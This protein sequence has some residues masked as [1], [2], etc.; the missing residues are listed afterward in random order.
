M[1]SGGLRT[2]GI[3]KQ[4]GLD[5]P[6]IT[7]VTVVRN[8]EKTLERTMLSVINQTYPNVEYIVI[9]G[10]SSDGTV[11]IIK[12]Y[13]DQIDYW[14]SEPDEGIYDAMNKAMDIAT[15][16]W[17]IFMNGGDCF[18]ETTIVNKCIEK[19]KDKKV[20]YYGDVY[21]TVIRKIYCGA[22]SRFKLAVKNICHQNIFY[23]KYIYKEY[24]YQAKYSPLSDY[25]YNISIYNKVCF[26]YLDETVAKFEYGGRSTSLKN[27]AFE[28][29]VLLV[30]LKNLGFFPFLWRIIRTKIVF[31][32]FNRIKANKFTILL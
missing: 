3:S 19:M 29:D 26:R 12:R 21:W 8:G 31:N 16:D 10:A 20:L 5:M 28:K 18:F 15:G 2:K 1:Q 25:Y 9:D 11:D 27:K 7:V 22:F 14:L 13:E 30:I 4:S 6:L 23:P 17:I 32:Y 24:A